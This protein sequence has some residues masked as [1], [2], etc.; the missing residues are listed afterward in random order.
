MYL[1]PDTRHVHVQY[2]EHSSAILLQELGH[3]Q[4]LYLLNDFP[5]STV[6]IRDIIGKV[7]VRYRIFEA[8]DDTAPD[9][10]PFDF[11]CKCV[12]VSSFECQ[13]SQLLTKS[14]IGQLRV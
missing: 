8:K 7:N 14:L 5:C 9:L 12:L 13:M 3:P 4:H 11:I 10:D 2:F 1:K 6:D